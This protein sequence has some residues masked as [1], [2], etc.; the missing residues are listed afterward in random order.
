MQ[1]S[2]L[3][4]N[5]ALV[6][7]IVCIS[8]FLC[9]I[10]LYAE[11]TEGEIEGELA[12]EGEVEGEIEGE[13]VAAIYYVNASSTA[14][15]PD[16]SSWA[17]AFKTLQAAVDKAASEG[18]GE[19]WVAKGT[20][21]STDDEVVTMKEWVD[22]YGGFAGNEVDR[23]AR[24]WEA[25]ESII[26]GEYV[27]RGVVGASNAVLDGFI[28]T[29]G[30]ATHGG[31]M[32]NERHSPTVTNCLFSDNE[33][34]V[35]DSSSI[36]NGNGGGIYNYI[37]SPVV[38]HCQFIEN[39][40]KKYGAGI[41]NL[42][43]TPIISECSFIK[44]EAF[45]GAAI[46]IIS[47]EAD[48]ST[49]EFV[50]NKT[51]SAGGAISIAGFDATVMDCTFTKNLSE[52]YGGALYISG[53]ASLI[54][55]CTFAENLA[56]YHGG[57]VIISGDA[58]PKFVD[59]DFIENRS[60]M[61]G[62]AIVNDGESSAKISNS[63]FTKNNASSDGGA[64]ANK[65]DAS[66]EIV[67]C[68]FIENSTI[69]N[70]GAIMNEDDSI[71]TIANS[72]FAKNTA[73]R[74]GAVVNYRNASSKIVNTIFTENRS[75]RPGGAIENGDD[76]FITI[77]N[78]SFTKNKA[79]LGA[80]V[81]NN[82]GTVEIWNSIIWDNGEFALINYNEDSVTQVAY[83]C[84]EGGYEGIGNIDEDPLF[85]DAPDNLQLAEGSPCIDT[86][87]EEEAPERDMLGRT[88]P[89]GLGVDMGVYEAIPDGEEEFPVEG[90]EVEPDE[91]EDIEPLEGEDV[92]PVEGEDVKPVEGEDV[93]PV[94]GEDVEPVEG[95]DV[96]PVEGED[97]KPVEGEDVEPVEGEESPKPDDDQD[98]PKGCNCDNSKS[99]LEDGFF[100]EQLQKNLSDWLLIGLSALTLLSFAAW[101]RR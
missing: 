18:L 33:V 74:G 22:L 49:C 29:R 58:S 27:R 31:G 34:I 53:T 80:A 1:Y 10:Q 11:P 57:A 100:R 8:M 54:S 95:E 59:C 60:F 9:G 47:S 72:R 75:E 6:W 3:G 76:S 51:S 89:R 73:D 4:K 97:V 28:I 40:A 84:I 38:S 90:E 67:N 81:Y 23:E 7:T 92:Q 14:A 64:V 96:E 99:L 93:Q 21:T 35:E 24:D 98:T 39:K 42:L 43:G 79:Y 82:V 88:R 36:S 44:N 78:S 85:I 61:D 45:S 32:M 66:P 56:Y 52:T 94:E 87:N 50:E 17:K 20:Y 63:R 46:E 70:G 48:V 65:A 69:S 86:G 68:D 83:S 25:N 30:R 5:N 12:I 55:G 37:A 15:S 77:V 26:D 101:R 2:F 71:V 62:G 41:Y 91:G 19:I 16:G 13:K